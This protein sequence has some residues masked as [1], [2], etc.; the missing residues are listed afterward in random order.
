MYLVTPHTKLWSRQGELESLPMS[1]LTSTP[2]MFFKFAKRQGLCPFVELP[3]E[4]KN[5]Q[6]NLPQMSIKHSLQISGIGLHPREWR[7]RCCLPNAHRQQKSFGLLFPKWDRCGLR[8][9]QRARCCRLIPAPPFRLTP[10]EA[11]GGGP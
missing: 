3:C 11:K 1:V 6:C 4:R 7:Q 8:G 5:L 2:N 9:K 10:N